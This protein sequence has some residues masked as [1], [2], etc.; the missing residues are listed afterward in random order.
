[1]IWED[2]PLRL[3]GSGPKKQVNP[4][5]AATHQR[6]VERLHGHFWRAFF[7]E[8]GIHSKNRSIAH[9]ESQ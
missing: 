7:V 1:L 6:R 2:S 3:T 5:Q 9:T 4:A 8:E